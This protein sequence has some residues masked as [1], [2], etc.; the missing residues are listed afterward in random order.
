MFA[1]VE[2]DHPFE[3]KIED[4]SDDKKEIDLKSVGY[5]SFGGQLKHAMNAHSKVDKTTE[6][7]FVFAA[8]KDVAMAYCSVFGPDRKMKNSF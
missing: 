2:V 1:L 5:D 8:D 7:L 6:E 4:S 3:L